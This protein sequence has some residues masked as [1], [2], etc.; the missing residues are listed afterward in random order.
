MKAA[1]TNLKKNN[2]KARCMI[3]GT[4]NFKRNRQQQ[5]IIIRIIII[6]VVVVVLEHNNSCF[7]S[8]T[9]VSIGGPCVRYRNT[10]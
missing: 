6:N 4:Q 5:V 10:K 9:A 8:C 7:F 2:E 3:H 1:T